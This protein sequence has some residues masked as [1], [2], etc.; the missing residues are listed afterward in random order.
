MAINIEDI[1]AANSLYRPGPMD[2][3]PDYIKGKTS[4]EPIVYD[5]KALEPILKPTYGVIVYQ[6][7]VMEIVRV[8]AGY[9]W[10][11]ADLVRR[12]M[13]KKHQDEIDA[14]RQIFVYGGEYT[15]KN[16]NTVIVPG[17]IKNKICDTD[18][19]SEKV[20]H[21]IYDKMVSFAKYAFNKSHAACYSV[22]AYQCAFLK[23]FF[24]AEFLMATLNWADKLEKIAEIIEDCHQNGVEVLPPDIN[25][26]Q[27]KFSTIDGKIIFGIGLIKGIG[28]FGDE[29]IA[30]RDNS[31]PFKDL[32][33]YLLRVGGNKFTSLVNAG[34]F[35]SFGYSRKALIPVKVEEYTNWIYD[36]L[37]YSKKILDE[38]KKLS[39]MKKM[40]GFVE[41]YDSFDQL[42]IR[43][44]E[45]GF[46]CPLNKTKNYPSVDSIKKKICTKEDKIN[47]LV[48]EMSEIE[49]FEP[50]EP[51]SLRKKLE[52]EKEVLGLY[53][54]GNPIDEYIVT[55]TSIDDITD[56]CNVVS[57]II[58]DLVVK[59]DKN[60][61]NYARFE[62]SDR[63]GKISCVMFSKNY[64]AAKEVLIQGNAV[65]L[66]GQITI[67]DFKSDMDGEDPQLFYKIKADSC[68]PL[69][70]QKS[71]YRLYV[72]N[73]EEWMAV[74]ENVVPYEKPNGDILQIVFE[75]S[76]ICR[77]YKNYVS[78]EISKIA[79]I[80]K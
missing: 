71:V 53:L 18:E 69:E 60:G 13:S 43:C 42:R 37:E 55:T 33:D 48:K 1:I 47:Q 52:A 46:A 36:M 5:C 17:C 32:K 12:A 10:G 28:S 50:D 14:E 16:G 67:D 25:L 79:K 41:E 11:R 35:D 75:H 49:A 68:T 80:V 8:L 65:T 29:I 34:C 76:G 23:E 77:I 3:I 72:K 70:K 39:G 20:A 4:N 24:P 27:A 6:E 56:K 19:E 22:T 40:L 51:E 30:E 21:K 63:T 59:K 38:R 61:N 9:N 64:E 66:T 44:K 58:E 57:G 54:T 74:K 31:G 45:E 73:M 7:Q 78:S 26:S 62:L 15:D 2:Y